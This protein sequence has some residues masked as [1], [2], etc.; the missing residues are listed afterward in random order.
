MRYIRFLRK[1]AYLGFLTVLLCACLGSI[2]GAVK[3]NGEPFIGVTEADL[4]CMEEAGV[5]VPDLTGVIPLAA[6]QNRWRNFSY[7][8]HYAARGFA[9]Y[10]ILMAV[11]LPIYHCR[12]CVAV[13]AF[14]EI[15]DTARP[16]SPEDR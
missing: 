2:R 4:A 12:F 10:C 5:S 15:E 7:A 3:E 14:L 11:Y 6:E 13:R 9:C 16:K 1:K 8:V